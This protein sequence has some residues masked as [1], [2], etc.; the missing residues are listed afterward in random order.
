MRHADDPTPL[1]CSASWEGEITHSQ[2][3]QGGFGYDPVFYVPSGQCTSAQ[4]TKE[5]KKMP[6]AI[7]ASF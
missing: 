1:I 7:A 5:Q 6:L 4:L 3:G 2:D